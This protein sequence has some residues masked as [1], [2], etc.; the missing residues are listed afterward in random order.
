MCIP[1]NLAMNGGKPGNTFG[2]AV[3][4]ML[5]NYTEK[6]KESLK[7]SGADITGLPSVECET[8][9]VG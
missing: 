8:E 6:W 5:N 2:D 4:D 7:E 1:M 9:P 3:Y